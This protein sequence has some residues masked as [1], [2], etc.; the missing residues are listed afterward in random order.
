MRNDL[1]DAKVL[2]V[3][4]ALLVA[5][6]VY[7]MMGVME[8]RAEASDHGTPVMEASDEYMPPR[9]AA[10]DAALA[11]ASMRA[12]ER[13]ALLEELAA[14]EE[15]EIESFDGEYVT[16][17]DGN[18]GSY[19][20]PYSDMYGENGPVVGM[21]G[22][23]GDPETGH[24]ETMYNA[25]AHA[26]ASEWTLDDEGFYHDANGRYVIG[27]SIDEIN[28]ETGQG[29]QYGDVVQTG[30]GEAVVYDYGQGVDN[31]HDFATIHY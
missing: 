1:P 9:L 2:A 15:L 14:Q 19:R 21:P 5:L 17:S 28:P 31:V 4:T 10:P 18:G 7:A 13:K 26:L 30:K 16:V 24:V 3:L 11:L 27:V 22:W 6:L 23:Y 25:S 29:Y 12:E 20:M 8:G